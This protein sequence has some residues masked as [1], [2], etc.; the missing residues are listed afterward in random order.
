MAKYGENMVCFTYIDLSVKNWTNPRN[1]SEK[2][3]K[4]NFFAR[5]NR[6]REDLN[7]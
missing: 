3:Q 7:F 5:L 6:I 2:K 4:I 1:Q